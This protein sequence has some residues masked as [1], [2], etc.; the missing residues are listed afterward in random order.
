MIL[1]AANRSDPESNELLPADATLPGFR[2]VKLQKLAAFKEV[3][4]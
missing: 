4:Q 1:V 3:F 2:Y